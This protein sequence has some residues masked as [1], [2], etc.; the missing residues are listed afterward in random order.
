M[1]NN[2][3]VLSELERLI[4]DS[5]DMTSRL[6]A[7]RDQVMYDLTAR[8]TVPCEP[9]D[10]CDSGFGGHALS[11]THDGTVYNPWDSQTGRDVLYAEW[12]SYDTLDTDGVWVAQD[13]A[14]AEKVV[15]EVRLEPRPLDERRELAPL[16]SSMLQM[17]SS[18]YR[19]GGRYQAPRSDQKS[20]SR[21]DVHSDDD[22][23]NVCGQVRAQK[24]SNLPLINAVIVKSATLCAEKCEVWFCADSYNL[25]FNVVVDDNGERMRYSMTCKYVQLAEDMTLRVAERL[26][27]YTVRWYEFDIS[28]NTNG[29]ENDTLS[30]IDAL[31]KD[32]VYEV[33]S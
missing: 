31:V 24:L 2:E 14:V 30:W 17:H 26:H 10:E 20:P 28:K 5:N 18:D 22:D 9:P 29:S 23:M 7:L 4:D 21:K 1:C 32:D 8:D 6:T 12:P 11:F 16:H 15:R 25:W 3:H 13:D 19:V 33:V 27:D